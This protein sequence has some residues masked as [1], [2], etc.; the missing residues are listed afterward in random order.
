MINT[1]AVVI[2]GFSRVYGEFSELSDEDIS[3]LHLEE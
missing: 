2:V 3:I 1:A